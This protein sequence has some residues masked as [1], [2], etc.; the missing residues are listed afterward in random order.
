MRLRLAI[1][2]AGRVVS[3]HDVTPVAGG[4][5]A[6]RFLEGASE[7]T[8]L[9]LDPRVGISVAHRVVLDSEGVPGTTEVQRPLN[10]AADPPAFAAARVSARTWL[11]YAAVGNGATRA[12]GLVDAASTDPPTA[13]VPGLGYGEP[14]ALDAV[15]SGRSVVFATEA[16]TAAAT[17][18]PHE[19]RLRRVDDRG[20]G[21]PLVLA[22]PATDPTLARRADGLLA[23]AHRSGRSVVVQLAR[24]AD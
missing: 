11:A 7:P 13:L 10:L 23:I 6:P 4:G 19:I 12:V 22:A 14:L 17:D 20:A 9:F 5:A 24:C 2:D 18:A 21:D 16:P 8:L 3:T 1:V 15:A